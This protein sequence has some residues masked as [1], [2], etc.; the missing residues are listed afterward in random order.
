MGVAWWV[1]PV[2]V[3][4]ILACM[5]G[6]S[7]YSG[8]GIMGVALLYGTKS[9]LNFS[10]EETGR[11]EFIEVSFLGLCPQGE[12][13][14]VPFPGGLCSP[15]FNNTVRKC[16]NLSLGSVSLSMCVSPGLK[17]WLP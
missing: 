9:P 3:L 17:S 10:L 1:W 11:H 16:S 4:S 5:V 14:S 6:V 12:G 15:L 8:C 2:E 7:I 13:T